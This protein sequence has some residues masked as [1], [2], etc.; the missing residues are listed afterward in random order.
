MH[1]FSLLLC[2]IR[3]ELITSRCR[4]GNSLF[5]TSHFGL[6]EITPQKTIPNFR[7]VPRG[8]QAR[9]VLGTA[10]KIKICQEETNPVIATNRNAKLNILRKGT[11][12]VESAPTKPRGVL[13][14]PSIRAAM[15]AKKAAQGEGK[16]NRMLLHA[17]AAGSGGCP[18][19]PEC[20]K[21][22]WRSP[23]HNAFRDLQVR[24]AKTGS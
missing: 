19:S 22:H 10:P 24:N 23:F 11:S 4:P 21:F 18:A 6:S 8:G 16:R 9:F 13:G 5:A 2:K 12:P 1:I 20:G 7:R 17:R 3:P 14:Q 15:A